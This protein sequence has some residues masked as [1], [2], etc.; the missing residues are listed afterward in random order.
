MLSVVHQNALCYWQKSA[1]GYTN[2]ITVT[3]WTTSSLRRCCNGCDPSTRRPR[4][5][6][7]GIWKMALRC[8]RYCVGCLISL[9]LTVMLTGSCR[10]HRPNLLR[11]RPTG[12]DFNQEHRLDPAMAESQTHLPPHQ[13]IYKRRMRRRSSSSCI[14]ATRSQ[15]DCNQRLDRECGNHQTSQDGPAGS[16]V[17]RAV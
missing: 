7:G 6:L 16:N 9:F 10:R 11:Q 13:H 14:L 1:S 15:G 5:R 3:G 12:D 17:Q 4:Y 8:G 2:T